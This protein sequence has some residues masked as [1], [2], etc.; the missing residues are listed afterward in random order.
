MT[1]YAEWQKVTVKKPQRITAKWDKK[2]SNV[3]LQINK[4]KG[5]DGYIIQYSTNSKFKKA[6]KKTVKASKGK[7]KVTLKKLN[8]NQK[9]YIRV[10]AYKLDSE[11]KKVKSKW[12][13]C[14]LKK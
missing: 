14:T 6:A 1:V 11:K 2:K 10:Q 4:V 7:T 12:K 3:R 8:K 13:K 5:A 9:Y